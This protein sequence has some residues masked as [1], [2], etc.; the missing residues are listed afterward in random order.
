MRLARQDLSAAVLM[1][2]V[3]LAFTA[4]AAGWGVLGDHHRLGA[5]A[6]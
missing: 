1:L 2:L 3:L 6:A 5:L 4:T